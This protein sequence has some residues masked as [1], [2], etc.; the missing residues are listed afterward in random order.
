MFYSAS[1]SNLIFQGGTL[2][3]SQTCFPCFMVH[4][5]SIL[6]FQ[7]GMGVW[8]TCIECSLGHQDLIPTFQTGMFH[9]SQTC[10]TCSKKHQASI[11]T[12]VLGVPSCLLPSLI[13]SLMLMRM[14][15]LL[16]LGVPTRTRLQDPGV[17]WPPAML[18]WLTTLSNVKVLCVL[19]W[20]YIV[21]SKN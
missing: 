10:G 21:W 6:T 11:K 9:L 19:H 16:A 3:P 2:A 4:Q 18:E 13:A 17:L 14:A 7:G 20:T 8:Q 5:A 1:S 15:Y 12:S